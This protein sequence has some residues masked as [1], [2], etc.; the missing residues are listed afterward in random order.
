MSFTP[1]DITDLITQSGMNSVNYQYFNQLL[2]HR[3]ITLND[4][5]DICLIENV[6][7][8]LKEF[9]EDDSTSPV[10]LILNSPGGD[11]VTGLPLIN[12]IDNYTKPLNIVVFGYAYSMGTILMCSGNKNPNVKKYC[13]PFST[14]LF[15]AGSLT[16]SGD[17]NN[18]RDYMDFAEKQDEEIKKYIFENTNI[19]EEQWDKMNR[20]EYYFN[21]HQ[22]KEYGLIDVIIGEDK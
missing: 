20:R 14:F 3:T 6:I 5:I 17:T 18:V 10:T 12:I 2:N 22:A 19:T 13:Y 4:A 15:H 9:E 21:A 7:L 11:V 8:P 16:A 1:I